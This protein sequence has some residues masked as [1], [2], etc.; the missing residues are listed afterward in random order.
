MN[1]KINELSDNDI[2]FVLSTSLFYIA[3]EI[4]SA[5]GKENNEIMVELVNDLMEFGF[6][7]I[8]CCTKEE[9]VERTKIIKQGLIAKYQTFK[10]NQK[11]EDN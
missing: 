3:K 11:V 8:D 1:W 5:D 6:S 7:S 2:I 9:R 4:S 10:A